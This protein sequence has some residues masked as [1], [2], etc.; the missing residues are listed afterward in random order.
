MDSRSTARPADRLDR[1]GSPFPLGRATLR[2]RCCTA[3]RYF[4]QACLPDAAPQEVDDVA[5]DLVAVGL[6]EDLVAG[7]GVDL[8]LEV[9]A[10][11]RLDRR[12]GV[13]QRDDR[14]LLAV[15]PERRQLA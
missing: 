7:A 15:D 14:V 11:D 12:A 8:L 13:D 4:V 5:D 9:R 6:V 1:M 2:G 10:L 3:Y